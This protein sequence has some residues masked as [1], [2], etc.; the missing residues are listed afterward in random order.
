[1][2]YFNLFGA[3]SF[4][5]VIIVPI[6]SLIIFYYVVKLAVRNGVIEANGIQ[7]K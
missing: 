3:L 5:F 6:I 2:N 4:I 7:N 1:M